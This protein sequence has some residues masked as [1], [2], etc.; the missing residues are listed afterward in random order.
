M[1]RWI[2]HQ[3]HKYMWIKYCLVLHQSFIEG[4]SNLLFTAGFLWRNHDNY[5]RKNCLI[6]KNCFL[7]KCVSTFQTSEE[8]IHENKSL[9]RARSKMWNIALQMLV[10]SFNLQIHDYCEGFRIVPSAAFFCIVNRLLMQDKYIQIMHAFHSPNVH[11][12]Q[13]VSRKRSILV[14]KNF[15][16]IQ[17][18]NLLEFSVVS[19]VNLN[20]LG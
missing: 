11:Y 5:L 6:V 7:P 13:I 4:F 10:K 8:N 16:S 3:R 15:V 9:A 14:N 12:R 18:M 2:F 19:V 17:A 1:R 20:N